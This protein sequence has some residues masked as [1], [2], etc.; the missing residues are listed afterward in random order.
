MARVSSDPQRREQ[1]LMEARS[2]FIECFAGG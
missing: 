1:Y 2:F